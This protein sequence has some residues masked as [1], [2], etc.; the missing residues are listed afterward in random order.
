M[1]AAIVPSVPIAPDFPDPATASDERAET[2]EAMLRA[3]SPPEDGAVRTVSFRPVA[4][5][6]RLRLGA[7]PE[8]LPPLPEERR[9]ASLAADGA[10]GSF[11]VTVEDQLIFEGP[12]HAPEHFARTQ[13]ADL[14]RVARAALVD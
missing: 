11:L 9:W 13:T 8:R 4:A 6:A 3:L 10:G 14:V 5:E 1:P 2:F 12:R 7:R